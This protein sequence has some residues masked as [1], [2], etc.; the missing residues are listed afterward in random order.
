[1]GGGLFQ[2]WAACWGLKSPRCQPPR[3]LQDGKHGAAY[4]VLTWRGEPQRPE[5]PTKVAGPL[6]KVWRLIRDEGSAPQLQWQSLVADSLRQERIAAKAAAG[7][8]EAAPAAEQPA[9]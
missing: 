4:G 3:F 8:A 5:A 1:M 9:S 2:H 6:K 7:Q